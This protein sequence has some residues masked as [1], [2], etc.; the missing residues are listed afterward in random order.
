L[1][2]YSSDCKKGENCFKFGEKGH[3]SYECKKGITC[4]NCGEVGHL[5][6]KCT[7]PKKAVGKVFA[8]NSEEVEHPVNLIRG[9]CFINCTPL[10]A[11]IDTGATLCFINYSFYLE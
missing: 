9:M 7:N 3:K 11:I 6:T 2:H 4:H 8:L 5:S 1:V 10:I